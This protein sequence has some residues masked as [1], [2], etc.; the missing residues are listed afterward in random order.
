MGDSVQVK[1]SKTDTG[2]VASAVLEIVSIDAKEG[3]TP[4]LP[5]TRIRIGG[6]GN[7][8]NRGGFRI[9]RAGGTLLFLKGT[10]DLHLKGS[11]RNLSDM[12]LK[13]NIAQLESTLDRL[14]QVRGVTFE[15]N[16]RY[17]PTQ[18]SKGQRQIGVL[19]QEVEAAFPEFATDDSPTGYK[20]IDYGR[21]VP[22]LIEAL[23]ELRHEKDGQ[24]EDLRAQV[25]ALQER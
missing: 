11:V 10:G 4:I 1:T 9:D 3:D 17:D 24:I 8:V 2:T 14:E 18:A 16:E 23:K 5:G 12:T 25:A 22:I 7:A 13:H 15:W 20:T 6:K 21:L 19:A